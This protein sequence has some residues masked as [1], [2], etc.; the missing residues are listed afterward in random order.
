MASFARPAALRGS[1]TIDEAA[2]FAALKEYELLKL[3]SA[4]R[5]ALA[6][7]RR[8]GLPLTGGRVK[9]RRSPLLQG[10]LMLLLRRRRTAPPTFRRRRLWRRPVVLGVGLRAVRGLP[11]GQTQT[12][13]RLHP[14]QLQLTGRLHRRPGLLGRRRRKAPPTFRRRRPWRRPVVLG[15]G[16]RAARSPAQGQT[17]TRKCLN[18]RLLQLTRRLHRRPGLLGRRRRRRLVPIRMR[19]PSGAAVPRVAR[20][21]MRRGGGPHA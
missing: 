15:A 18:L 2:R 20:D 21:I 19:P 3:L 12:R 9:R 17:Q 7:A 5:R 8:L 6:T 16:L 14:Q 10:L 4:D 13:K 11:H 1:W